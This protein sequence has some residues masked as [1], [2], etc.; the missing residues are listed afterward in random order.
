MRHQLVAV[1]GVLV[2]LATTARFSAAEPYLEVRA[3]AKCNDCHT[4]LTG[5]G[6]R[7]PFAHIHAHDILDD[8]DL[9]PIPPTVKGFNGQINEWVSIGGDLRVRNTTIFQDKFGHS[10]SIPSDQ[11]FRRSVTSNT[12]EVQEFLGYAQVDLFPDYVTLYSDFN[13]NGGVTNRE[14]FGLIRGLLPYDTYLKAGRLYP[15]YGLRVWDDT[16]YIRGRVGYTF[17]NPDVGGE[18]G[19]APGPY[20]LATSITNGASGD[21]SVQVTVNGYGLYE[22][23]PVVRNVLAGASYG[24]QSDKRWVAG[25]YAGSNIWRLTYLAEFDYIDDRTVASENKRDQFAAYAELDF[26]LFS[27]L[28]IRGTFDYVKVNHDQ[29]QVRYCIGAE[30]FINR[31]IQPRIQYRIN[32]GPNQPST[33]PSVL[34][35]N[36]DELVFELHFF[37]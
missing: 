28:N 5:G 36:Q 19:F 22:D 4:N 37:F 8:L 27:W 30:P 3:G 31:F 26:L 32:N 20:F 2:A 35:E 11:A 7:T 29:N 24:F 23:V 18:I 9:L 21:K 15:T 12:T 1:L 25:V 17:Q 10:N 6:K 14:A 16:A 33:N 34:T 13:L